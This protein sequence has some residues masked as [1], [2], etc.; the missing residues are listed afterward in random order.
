MMFFCHRGVPQTPLAFVSQKIVESPT[1]LG[2]IEITVSPDH[3]SHQ[4]A[5]TLHGHGTTFLSENYCPAGSIGD[6]DGRKNIEMPSRT[7]PFQHFRQPNPGQP[8]SRPN[9]FHDQRHR[10]PPFQIP[11]EQANCTKKKLFCQ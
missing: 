10:S 9:S 3:T 4:L 8:L 1:K 11:K 7:N 6:K 2:E 5:T